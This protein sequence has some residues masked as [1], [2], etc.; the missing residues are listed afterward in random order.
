VGSSS[1]A[2]AMACWRLSYQHGS[3]CRSRCRSTARRSSRYWECPRAT[4]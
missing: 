1:T 2:R 3:V 4:G